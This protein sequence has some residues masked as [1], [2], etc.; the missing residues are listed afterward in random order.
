MEEMERNLLPPKAQSGRKIHILYGLGGIGKTQLAIAYV[1]KHSHTYSAIV[2]VNGNST[3]TMLQSL[4][5]FA[6][7]AGVSGVL[8]STANTT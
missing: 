1:R 4:A 3:D 6:R 5:G 7:R 2:W 8:D